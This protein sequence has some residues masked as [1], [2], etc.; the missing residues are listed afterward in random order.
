MSGRDRN[1]LSQIFPDSQHIGFFAEHGAF[2]RRAGSKEWQ[3]IV[4]NEGF[5]WWDR[6]RRIFSGFTAAVSESW[7]EEKSA[8]L[9]WHYRGNPEEGKIVAPALR[10][11]LQQI[12][13]KHGWAV[14]VA[15]GKCIVE[16]RPNLVNKGE[17]VRTLLD[18]LKRDE[19]RLPEFVLCAG[20]DA[21]D[22]GEWL[23]RYHAVK[24]AYVTNTVRHVPR[25]CRVRGS[26]F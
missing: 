12:A 5:P 19:Q 11:L 10:E 20:D 17:V 18:E 23:L 21:T 16:A 4:G 8:A 24:G 26:T 22:E 7:V 1:F 13:I 9:V 6:F 3:S 25:H 15:E 14:H 2:V